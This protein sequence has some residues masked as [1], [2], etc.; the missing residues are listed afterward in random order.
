MHKKKKKKIGPAHAF[1]KFKI[2]N[3]I[4]AYAPQISNYLEVNKEITSLKYYIAFFRGTE[5]KFNLS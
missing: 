5:I 3:N 2:I 1:T 4:Y